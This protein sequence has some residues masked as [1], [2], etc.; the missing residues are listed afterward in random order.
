MCTAGFITFTETIQLRFQ[1]QIKYI[2]I[3]FNSNSVPVL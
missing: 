1:E 2:L 3:Q